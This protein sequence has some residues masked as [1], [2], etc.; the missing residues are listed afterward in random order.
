MTTVAA[1]L[2]VRPLS[3]VIGA[4]VRGLDLSA[5]LGAATVAAVRAA[6]NAHHV[7]F[8]REQELTPE[9]Q[10]A[11][12]GQF[13]EVTEAHP[14]IPSIDAH[15]KVLAID[16]A[17]GDKASWWHTDVTFLDTPPL[18]SILHMRVA[19]EVGGDTSWVSLQ[20]AYDA[21]SEPVRVLCDK[22]I[23]WHHDPWFAADVEANGGYEWD[24]HWRERL[25]PASHPVVRTHPETGRNGLFVNPHFTKFVEGVSKVESDALLDMLYRHC[26][27]P[28]F[29]CRFRWKVGAVAFWDNRATWHYAIDDY[30]DALRIAHRV[31]LRGD[32]PYGPAR[33]PLP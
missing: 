10:V 22:L 2:D 8:F 27:R 21:L 9:A 7:V 24:G 17:R 25:F 13:G 29:S 12:A 14:V 15:P 1:A 3:P 4:E 20:A 6:L 11:F 16:A 18:G 26:Q 33:G 31:T 28:E 19:P 30:G 32:R 5:P 23:A